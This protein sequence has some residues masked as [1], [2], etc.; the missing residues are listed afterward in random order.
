MTSVVHDSRFLPAVSSISMLHWLLAIVR[1]NRRAVVEFSLLIAQTSILVFVLN[2]RS[3]SIWQIWAIALALIVGGLWSFRRGDRK[4][5]YS[6][7][8][9]FGMLVAGVAGLNIYKD[10]TYDDRYRSENGTQAHVVWH[11]VYMGLGFHPEAIKKY[12]L[13]PDDS[14]VYSHALKY[15]EQNPEAVKR[16]GFEGTKLYEPVFLPMG[17]GGY[18]KAVKDMFFAFARNDPTYVAEA[19]LL[20]KPMLLLEEFAWQ[21]GIKKQFPDWVK[22]NPVHGP[23]GDLRIKFYSLPLLF[24][25]FVAFLA[26]R[27]SLAV[28]EAVPTY[29][30]VGLGA[31][32]SLI[33]SMAVGPFYYELPV[34]FIIFSMMLILVSMT[35][36]D[37]GLR[38][39][40]L[41]R[42]ALQKS[43]D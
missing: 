39:K 15:L 26:C 4:R 3:S 37:F 7:V 34:V 33:P 14:T 18:D 9:W 36:I 1:S 21:V 28:R 41:R 2:C 6:L 38:W 20:Y 13:L 5:I 40:L 19:L 11:N 22:M 29:L 31:T 23:A 24:A 35:S 8:L 43:L 30:V 10:L 25:M 17:W 42:S 16:L 27:G 12:E 32:F